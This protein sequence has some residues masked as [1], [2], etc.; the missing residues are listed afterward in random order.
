MKNFKKVLGVA[1]AL[2]MVVGAFTMFSIGTS[3]EAT[4]TN[5][6]DNVF[7]STP[8][9][10]FISE[11][12]ITFD[13]FAGS[14]TNK[15]NGIAY[16]RDK[17]GM[18]ISA[19]TSNDS[20]MLYIVKQGEGD[21]AL[22]L[23]AADGL[24]Y[25][26]GNIGN[27]KNADKYEKNSMLL[28]LLNN[29]ESP[30]KFSISMEMTITGE[31]GKVS[32][33]APTSDNENSLITYYRGISVFS[34]N[35]F[36]WVFKVTAANIPAITGSKTLEDGT[37]LVEIADSIPDNM[38]DKGY[39]YGP[40]GTIVLRSTGDDAIAN[41]YASIISGKNWADN[42]RSGSCISEE[43]MDGDGV[44]DALTYT[45]GVPFQV[46]MDFTRNSSSTGLE[47]KTYV[48]DTHISTRNVKVN[49]SGNASD[50]TYG[51]RIIDQDCNMQLDNIKLT[52][53]TPVD[54]HTGAWKNVT[55]RIVEED[56]VGVSVI[57][58][59]NVCGEEISKEYPSVY[60]QGVKSVNVRRSSSSAND[61]RPATATTEESIGRTYHENFCPIWDDLKTAPFWINFDIKNVTNVNGSAKNSNCGLV[62]WRPSKDK[63][64]GLIRLLDG[65]KVI[66]V[67][68]A[69]KGG[70][71]YVEDSTFRISGT[72]SAPGNYS[73]HIF[74][75]PATGNY[76]LY[77]DDLN[78][79][80]PMF[81]HGS[82]RVYT[83]MSTTSANV[84]KNGDQWP[85]LR[86]NDVNVADY[87]I[88]NFTVT[89]GASADE[90]AHSNSL[91][92]AEDKFVVVGYD[93][94]STG[95]N[96]YCGEAVS[97]GDYVVEQLVKCDSV[98]YGNG[99]IAGLP[100]KGEYWIAT[101]INIRSA[102]ALEAMKAADGAEIIAL[103]DVA[104]DLIEN[105]VVPNTYQYAVKV[106][107]DGKTAD[108]V[109]YC[110][111]K[112][113]Y[114]AEDVAVFDKVTFGNTDSTD[115][116][117]NLTKVAKIDAEGTKVA[118]TYN[119][120]ADN[121]LKPCKHQDNG[122]SYSTDAEGGLIYVYTCSKC[123]E[124][125]V[126]K[127]EDKYSESMWTG[128][129]K[130][131]D[132]KI[133]YV[134]NKFTNFQIPAEFRG[135][136][137]KPY[138]LKFKLT[139]NSGG[140]GSSLDNGGG[141]RN[142]CNFDNN[143]ASVVRAYAVPNPAGG[144]YG[145]RISVE[146]KTA[147]RI[148]IAEIG[149]GESVEITLAVTP[150]KATVDI[151][152]NGVYVGTRDS[153]T[154][155]MDAADT[156]IR[157]G[158]GACF[159]YV[160]SDFA[161]LGVEEEPHTHSALWLNDEEK[162]AS[163]LVIN[164]DNTIDYT[165][166]CYC[167][168]TV[169][170]GVGNVLTNPIVPKYKAT[171]AAEVVADDIIAPNT[172]FVG[173]VM[174][175][176]LPE[177]GTEGIK[178][179]V[180]I[181][182][183]AI[184][185]V[186]AE[187]AVYLGENKT[188]F[189]MGDEY[190]DF[191][192]Y[193]NYKD[194]N[195]Y[196]G[197]E[198]LGAIEID[199]ATL[200]AVVGSEGMG[201]FH[202]D[203]MA[204]VKFA[205]K[206]TVA[207]TV[208]TDNHTH[209]FDP[210][211]AVFTFNDARTSVT[212]D[213]ICTVCDRPAIDGIVTNLYDNAE[214]TDK[215]EAIESVMATPVGGKV[216]V[217]SLEKYTADAGYYWFSADFVVTNMSELNR[218]HILNIGGKPVVLIDA[219][220]DLR[221]G[222]DPTVVVGKVAKDE[223]FNVTLAVK[224]TEDN[225]VVYIYIDGNYCGTIELP[226]AEETAVKVGTSSELVLNV[227]N[228]KLATFGNNGEGKICTYSCDVHEFDES[229]TVVEYLNINKFINKFAVVKTCTVCGLDVTEKA[230]YNAYSGAVTDIADS[231]GNVT[232]TL[233]ETAYEGVTDSYWIVA[234]VNQRADSIGAFDGFV[235]LIGAAD[236]T[237]LAVNSNGVL[238]FADGTEIGK[239]FGEKVTRNIAIQY[240]AEE[241]D[242]TEDEQ[243]IYAL[244]VNVY[245]D[246]RF[247][248][249]M[250]EETTEVATIGTYNVFGSEEFENVKF[251]NIKSLITAEAGDEIEFSFKKDNSVIPCAHI[252]GVL[253]MDDVTFTTLKDFF[254]SCATCGE[255]VYATYDVDLY[256]PSL[257]SGFKFDAD[258]TLQFNNVKY[259]NTTTD[260]LGKSG[261]DFWLSYKVE[262]IT[263]NASGIHGKGD[264]GANFM[265]FRKNHK[266]ILRLYSVIN[267]E[268]GSYYTDRAYLRS[269]N[270]VD[271]PIAGVI[272]V[273]GT[274]KIDLHVNPAT[275]KVDLYFNG[276]YITSRTN[277]MGDNSQ[278]Q[279]RFMDN[280]WGTFKLSEFEFVT[281]SAFT[282]QHTDEYSVELGYM[283]TV[284]YGEKTLESTYKCICGEIV[285]NGI[286]AVHV[287]KI[288][289]MQNVTAATAISYAD[290]IIDQPYWVS[291]KV[292]ADAKD[293]VV[294]SYGE[295]AI[296]SVVN[297]KYVIGDVET[298]IKPYGAKTAGDYDI[299]SINVFP[300]TGKI[301]TYVNGAYAG[302]V[303]ANIDA[304]QAYGILLGGA[305]NESG[306]AL[307]FKNIKVVSLAN[308]FDGN[309]DLYECEHILENQTAKTT[310]TGVEFT[311]K[312]CGELVRTV[313]IGSGAKYTNDSYVSPSATGDWFNLNDY[314]STIFDSSLEGT[315]FITFD[316]TP[317]AMSASYSGRK[318]WVTWTPGTAITTNASGK[319]T[320]VKGSGFGHILSLK[321]V[322]GNNVVVLGDN[323]VVSDKAIKEKST[324]NFV[325]EVD[326]ANNLY[327]VY[328]DGDYIGSTGLKINNSAKPEY[329]LR[330]NNATGDFTYN[331]F[332][333]YKP[334]SDKLNG[335]DVVVT[336]Q[337]LP[338]AHY[339]DT[340]KDHSISIVDGKIVQTFTCA[341]AKCG[342]PVT[343]DT[344]RDAVVALEN[345]YMNV[346]HLTKVDVGD[347][348]DYGKGT[349]VMSFE[350][351]I[352][353]L[354]LEK[355][356]A[357]NN[358]NGGGRS[359]VSLEGNGS[360]M[361]L[362]AFGHKYVEGEGYEDANG[363][364]YADGVVDFRM[365]NSEDSNNPI[366][367]SKPMKV[368]D[369]LKIA[370]VID[371]DNQRMV[372][373]VADNETGEYKYFTSRNSIGKRDAGTTYL[374]ILD[375]N[376]GRFDFTNF[377]I[378][379]MTVEDT[380]QHEIPACDGTNYSFTCADCGKTFERTHNYVAQ[381]DVTG[382]WTKYTCADCGKTYLVFN[383]KAVI[384]DLTYSSKTELMKLLTEMYYPVFR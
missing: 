341:D 258:G 142:I 287:N 2:A 41:G 300:E 119:D 108:I 276:Q 14:T 350:M 202:F 274:Y 372:I 176:E 125:V 104:I 333:I 321:T 42:G 17:A 281:S 351:T 247:A 336:T 7:A 214:T 58:V 344:M 302:K 124:K 213:Y 43:M 34:I 358:N 64:S 111:N 147:N 299:V 192:I 222:T 11:K 298:D 259:I 354:W 185:S 368:G 381:G 325:I 170:A 231:Y 236:K 133:T 175:K 121:T 277:A 186:D 166:Q 65:G 309:V 148:K 348:L 240:I 56:G 190:C 212:A 345:D 33:A 225:Y 38:K 77:I 278:T 164:K 343:L 292:Y 61:S 153:A 251:Y 85:K 286:A 237:L 283:P 308:G 293:T 163:S 210:Y 9:Y 131:V 242:Q 262:V 6:D 219:N 146:S 86:F 96:C 346:N 322:D 279:I 256:D 39:I 35:S 328:V 178:A 218:Q 260:I 116:R 197:G 129:L 53:E 257:N 76:D 97:A 143:F 26:N 87:R 180:S 189:V 19:Q 36:D 191:A 103:G 73:F 303:D 228:V 74:V 294:Y 184:V 380:C 347:A 313:T 89:R 157:F 71:N 196:F 206:D 198:F 75:T 338:H 126:P 221:I 269:N 21:Y 51:V 179:L 113:V 324:Y 79:S 118:I 326:A 203:K 234:D 12:G 45:L 284:A 235:N 27:A 1:L 177:E 83:L 112:I 224:T 138:Q 72:D 10:D 172:A 375:N 263:L 52:T 67:D 316:V 376:Y 106:V 171:E 233:N 329:T 253:S 29:P 254:Y 266:S 154:G 370:Y 156:Q 128:E 44:G 13:D 342:K 312:D 334:Q 15:D 227:T 377:K 320:D 332:K 160:A 216:I 187:G 275:R 82:A 130:P 201:I 165:Y 110:N 63:Y 305:K 238:A 32:G 81:Y 296:V 295:T 94:L 132:G 167:G 241:I 100:T 105:A 306:A 150:A 152:A 383:D 364:T 8:A 355:I 252:G 359:I 268:T 374:R 360:L 331:N 188:D 223:M 135:A 230:V 366:V 50:W 173:S 217:D 363:D 47:I 211:T 181:G 261:P 84:D 3:A 248:A 40:D 353:E 379:R 98:Y 149:I 315:F 267:P 117:F 339:P 289:D 78:D 28:D 54:L 307:S 18:L 161:L 249:S 371:P 239:Y 182:G 209:I 37:T 158:D 5:M 291:A 272:H 265:N 194:A 357:Q 319:I 311:C 123:G 107:A 352:S 99:E 23:S 90:H 285:T 340:S 229:K 270:T 337:P 195:V 314:K 88:E 25:V 362:R 31:S 62:T 330:V 69:G 16:T 365:K 55:R 215:I 109:V 232:A 207:F 335:N 384:A 144:F 250:T 297:G 20:R 205:T 301:N 134:G 93:S 244:T 139:L 193:R 199:A 304:T 246:G 4:Y 264:G 243:T 22:D 91:S 310:S 226:V 68:A 60:Y 70:Y 255:R 59:C 102:A 30:D 271:A 382:K 162:A 282:H 323:K 95:Y 361:L 140:T 369:T 317:T 120:T 169:V 327:Y 378:V 24:C 288:E 174:A 141:G 114:T 136:D 208:G 101:D 245:V 373:Y 115:V 145:D 159:G 137:G 280:N 49:G 356:I 273:G 367:N 122:G 57:E 80:A 92:T 168:E 318:S 127:A 155:A 183:N 220:S 66:M 48:D 151:Y 204:V 200:E 290:V 349:Y 46:R